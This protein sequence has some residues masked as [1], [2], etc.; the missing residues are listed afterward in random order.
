MIKVFTPRYIVVW[1]FNSIIGSLE[2]KAAVKG[3]PHRLKLAS[4]KVDLFKGELIR[5]PPLFLIA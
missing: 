4:I 2:K 1:Q 5:V 3:T